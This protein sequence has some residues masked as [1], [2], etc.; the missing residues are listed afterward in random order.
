MVINLLCEDC[1]DRFTDLRERGLD[2]IRAAHLVIFVSEAIKRQFEKL[3]P[4]VEQRL[5]AIPNGISSEF[6]VPQDLGAR[7]AFRKS[8]NI[9]ETVTVFLTTARIE[10]RKG[11]ILCLRALREMKAH[12]DIS[13]I[14]LVLS[15]V[16]TGGSH[17]ETFDAFVQEATRYGLMENIIILGRRDDIP[18]LLDACDAFILTSYAEGGLPLSIMEAM[19]KGRPVITTAIEEISAMVDTASTILVPSP[20]L[21]EKD[22]I[23]A[24]ATAMIYLHDR[25]D[26]RSEMGRQAGI[27]A[28]RLFH[29]D[30][31][32]AA[33]RATLLSTPE[34]SHLA[35]CD[36]VDVEISVQT[37]LRCAG[38]A[39][40]W[41]FVRG[42]NPNANPLLSTPIRKR[43]QI[44]TPSIVCK[45][46]TGLEPGAI[47]NFSNPEQMYRHGGDGWSHPESDG[48]WTD[49]KLSIIKLRIDNKI[50]N[51]E[52]NKISYVGLIFDLT[53][54]VPS[55]HHQKTDIFVNG[56]QLGSWDFDAHKRESRIIGI[57]IGDT[58][59]KQRLEI[60]L[61]HRSP[62][63]PRQF[64]MGEDLRELAIF[65]HSITALKLNVV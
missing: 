32:I 18:V 57:A 30:R 37:M 47:V 64:G 39:F 51:S 61:V 16:L 29:Q 22:C 26:I 56:R 41:L 50:W 48:A 12:R 15:G 53:P 42:K 7:E 14:Q 20:N 31:M 9:A 5:L 21:S 38:R 6:F 17:K 25:P 40:C 13:N 28:E 44:V 54:F 36:R 19:A 45:A 43:K 27:R 49:G 55:G 11:Q 24:I 52:E 10:P 1:P 46:K 2:A 59:D 63:S 8:L 58:Q 62:A 34:Q 65:L 4:D 35:V 60:R 33:Y 3:F 23:D